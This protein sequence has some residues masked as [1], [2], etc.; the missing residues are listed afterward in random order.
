MRTEKHN[1][2]KELNLETQL[3]ELDNFHKRV[4]ILKLK[5]GKSGQKLFRIEKVYFIYLLML[6]Q[7]NY[8]LIKLTIVEVTISKIF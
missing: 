4:L 6:S 7:S 5:K 1:I 2:E 3:L 8:S